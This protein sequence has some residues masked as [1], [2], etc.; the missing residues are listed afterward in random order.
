[1]SFAY[2]DI[3]VLKDFDIKTNMSKDSNGNKARRDGNIA[4][5]HEYGARRD[6]YRVR[7]SSGCVIL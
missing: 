4:R 3:S 7:D 5:R 6:E 1:M 2:D